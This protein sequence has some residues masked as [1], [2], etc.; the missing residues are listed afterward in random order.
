[1][2]MSSSA[3]RFVITGMSG[4]GKTA[5]LNELRTLGYPCF[6]EPA[7]KILE[8]RLPEEGDGWAQSFIALMLQH[9]LAD[10]NKADAAQITFFD[11]GLPDTVA[12]AIRFGVAPNNCRA[13]AEKYRYEATVFVAPPW[14]EIFKHDPH[15]R[16]S[17]DD[18]LKFH[19]L[20]VQTY[21]DLGYSLIELPR[22]PV[23]DRAAYI[24]R[25][26]EDGI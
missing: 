14:P 24:C 13:A 21:E 3:R 18:Y 1:M 17:F 12:Y 8:A 10:F 26:I 2:S 7:R 9:S 4:T 11:R 5:L 23:H 22:L 6:E 25:S 20:L 19:N 15:R 16:A